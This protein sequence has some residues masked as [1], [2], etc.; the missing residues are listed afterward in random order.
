[1]LRSCGVEFG[2][3]DST[4]ALEALLTDRVRTLQDDKRELVET[5]GEVNDAFESAYLFSGTQN[6]EAYRY[7]L[8]AKVR[9]LL[10]RV[11]AGK[12]GHAT[13]EQGSAIAGT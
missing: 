4:P 9:M 1:M 11:T 3:E 10:R 8:E 12:E 13:Q 7:R 2:N 5:L 6:S